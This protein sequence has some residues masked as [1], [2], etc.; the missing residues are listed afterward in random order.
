LTDAQK[1]ID[2]VDDLDRLFKTHDLAYDEAAK[3][4]DPVAEAQAI[5][6]ADLQLMGGMWALGELSDPL[7]EDYRNQ[8]MKVF[9][10]KIVWDVLQIGSGLLGRLPFIPTWPS[11]LFTSAQK[12][13]LVFDPLTLDLDGDGLETVGIDPNAPILFDHNT[14]GIKTGTGWVSAD[15][16][17]LVMDR[18]GNGSIDTGQ[19]L[20]GDSTLKSN[21]QLATDGF[22]ALADLDSNGDGQISSA[23]AQFASLR[24]WRDLNQDGISQSGEL[25]TLAEQN[26]ASL[27][28][29]QTANSQTLANENQIADL[30]TYTRTDGSIGT[31]GDINLAADTFHREFTSTL[32]TTAVAAL[33]DMQGSGVLRDLRQAATQSATLQN[34]LTQYS[35]ATTREAQLALLDQLLDAWADTG[36]MAESLDARVDAMPEG[37]ILYG[38]PI[39]YTTTYR[40]FGSLQRSFTPMTELSMEVQANYWTLNDPRITHDVD[41]PF[42]SAEFRQS[43]AEWTQKMH[44]LESFNGRY[45]FGLPGQLQDTGAVN[46]MLF[47]DVIEA[48]NDGEWRVAV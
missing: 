2:G 26:I 4:T 15:D 9:D 46:G 3:M 42:L 38:M 20:F 32:D 45:F 7:A 11:M 27:S 29:A 43:I 16:G 41:N 5:L 34:L 13:R 21:G 40:S 12:F 17:M 14:D 24:V 39:P 35:A 48:A 18:N 22:D 8:A 30:G 36:G 6:A 47:G 37:E 23:D 44:I 25:T 19:E 1:A 31:T 33:P 28:T 10:T